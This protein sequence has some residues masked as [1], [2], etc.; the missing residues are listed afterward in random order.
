M[1]DLVKLLS[2]NS[3]AA[4]VFA[5]AV[6]GFLIVVGI[7]YAVA[8]AQGRAVS[9]WPPSIG[10][11]PA[12]KHDKEE[13][14]SREKIEKEPVA[15]PSEFSNPIVDRG[16]MLTGA[17]GKSYRITSGFYAGANATIYKAE[18]P[19]LNL[20]IAK[21]Y[22]RG[23][24]PN[25]PS[26]ELF[27][28]EQR[29]AEILNHR[30]IVKTLDRGLRMGYPFAI[31]EYF[32]GGTLRDWLTT[33]EILPRRDIA[34][35]AAQLA[36][37]LD[38]A[39]S[40]GVIHRDVKPGNVLFESDPNGRVAL[41]DFG[42]AAIMG[43]VERDITAVG[44]EFSG[45]PAYVAPEVLQGAQPRV[46]A[47]IYSLGVVLYEMIVGV[48]PFDDHRDSLA[49]MRAKVDVDAPDIRQFRPEVPDEVA[50]SISLL[51]ARNPE[52]RPKSARAAVSGITEWLNRSS[53]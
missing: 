36:D 15:T 40:C 16:T 43:A 45:T 44:A 41:S 52:M 10:E 34:S 39:H 9:F 3:T 25:S 28:Q 19:S 42:I 31:M 27:R 11:R 23:L 35:V 26:W 24:M 50:K 30:N 20:V 6:L 37:A 29:T 33:H 17:T 1:N 18:D 7:L 32:G 38:Y 5:F 49:I 4:M 13:N 22:W 8:F 51:L 21:I 2:T 12:L 53:S 14:T 46:A 47:D 48:V